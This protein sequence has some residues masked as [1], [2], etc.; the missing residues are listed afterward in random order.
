MGMEFFNGLMEENM[1]VLG[2]KVYIILL[3]VGK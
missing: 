2:S 1:L 3:I